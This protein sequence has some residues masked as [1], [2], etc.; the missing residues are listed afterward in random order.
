MP[1]QVL[2]ERS[3][4]IS[5]FERVG[6]EPGESNEL[7]ELGEEVD[8]EAEFTLER[9]EQLITVQYNA[10]ERGLILS[11]DGLSSSVT[12]LF[13]TQQKMPELLASI[14]EFIDKDKLNLEDYRLFIEAVLNRGVRVFRLEKGQF[15]E[16]FSSKEKKEILV[17][18]QRF[19]EENGWA[20]IE[21][22]NEP[23]GTG[24]PEEWDIGACYYNT[25]FRIYFD[26]NIDRMLTHNRLYVEDSNLF[27]NLYIYSSQFKRIIAKIDQWK[28]QLDRKNYDSF[29][30]ELIKV[31]DKVIFDDNGSLFELNLNTKE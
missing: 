18:S 31:A 24:N 29:V 12:F 28:N 3:Q 30:K 14:E 22:S 5:F 26:I 25:V 11:V 19:L 16:V 2:N 23:S 4:I 20:I 27:S 1:E 6:W 8:F 7:F 21:R 13:D 17:Q 10:E 9:N 15:V